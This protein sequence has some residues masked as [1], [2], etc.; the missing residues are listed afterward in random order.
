T[1]N[2]VV[3]YKPNTRAV[4]RHPDGTTTTA[5]I[6]AQGWNSTK[7]SYTRE[8]PADRTRIAVIG[9]SYVHAKFVEP[10]ESFAAVLETKLRDDG[11]AADVYRFGMDGAPLSQYLHVLRREVVAYKPDVVVVPLIHNDFDEMYRG[12]KTRYA[13]S[14]MKLK[15]ADFADG[16]REL[17]PA[18]FKPGLAA[19]LRASAMFRYLYYETNLYLHAKRW[20][21]RYWWGGNEDW[22][23]KF[24][25]SAVDIRKIKDHRSNRF[26]ARYVLGEMKALGEEHGFKL[27]FV[28][29]GVREAIYDKRS[30]DEYEVGK[31]NRIA[32]EVTADL[33]LAFADLQGA[34]ATDFATHGKRFEFPFDWHWNGRGNRIVADVLA[35]M[36]AGAVRRPDGERTQTGARTASPDRS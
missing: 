11:I 22:D 7:P 5:T 31:L 36:I 10:H 1:I 15:R 13:S 25:S 21:S 4:F 33:G 17:P 24:V 28:M 29:D 18:D 23:P 16:V 9:D 26:F 19:R 34:F 3:R 12:V 2:H 20:I 35:D 14:F 30:A 27:V 32:A 6:N 8:K